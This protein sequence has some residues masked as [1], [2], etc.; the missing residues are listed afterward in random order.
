VQRSVESVGR[1]T[2]LPEQLIL[3]I[4]SN[5]DMYERCVKEWSSPLQPSGLRVDVMSDMT[6]QA[7]REAADTSTGQSVPRRF[8][9][10]AARTAASYRAAGEIVVFLDDDAEATPEWLEHLLVPYLEPDVVAVSGAPHP[11]FQT[12]RP[13][14]F[15]PEFDWV[16]GCAYVG[17]PTD[18]APIRH[19]IGAS[20][21]VRRQALVDIG[22]I[23]SID[24]DDMDLSH[25]LADAFP[26]DRIMY[27]PHAVI[28]HFVP[29]QRVT[30]H[31]F[32]RR[33]FQVNQH[34]IR[35]FSEMGTAAN[36]E[37]ER[38]FVVG[39]LR[40]QVGSYLREVIK[41]DVTGLLR[42]VAAFVGIAMAGLGNL[43]GRWE[44]VKKR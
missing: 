30:W 22:G 17:V 27:Q 20:M 35:A 44:R 42:L 10:G 14:W 2:H 28:Y 41:G 43:Y 15:P 32:W 36:L 6:N 9:A 29:A 31:Y 5:P 37:S 1:Q 4:D 26:A 23:R 21:S 13:R 24:F 39:F 33:C 19:M 40:D 7:A 8:G 3:C 16:F 25:R 18:L 11:R 38:E 34:K 12:R